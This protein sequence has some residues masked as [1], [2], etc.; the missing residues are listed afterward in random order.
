MITHSYQ[1]QL[2]THIV[3]KRSIYL[4][5]DGCTKA[6]NIPT[7]IDDQQPTLTKQCISKIIYVLEVLI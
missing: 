4:H 7:H 3:Q 6:I 5:F 2:I 1:S